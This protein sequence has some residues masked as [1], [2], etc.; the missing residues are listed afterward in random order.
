MKQ[1]S[2][3]VRTVT[4]ASFAAIFIFGAYIIL[5]GH[6]TPGGG[7]QG[8]AIIGT[9]MALYLVAFG[10]TKW[11]KKLLMTFESVGLLGFIGAGFLGLIGGYFFYNVVAGSGFPIFGESVPAVA[12]VLHPNWAP[13][14]TAGTISLMNVSVGIEVVAGL[15]LVVIIMGLFAFEGKED[16]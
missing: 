8:G 3:V 7:F 6:L 4:K 12:G 15:T 16:E 5:H 1:M 10:A 2:V 14:M 11:K 9:L 13:L